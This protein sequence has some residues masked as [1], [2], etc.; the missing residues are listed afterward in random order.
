QLPP[1]PLRQNGVYLITGGMGGLGLIFAEYLAKNLQS[2]LVL[3]SR[4]APK[5]RQEEKLRQLKSYGAEVLSLQADVSK[6]EDVQMAVRE[7]KARFSAIH[8]VIHAAGVNRDAFILKKTKEEME[9][10]LGPKV[11][12]TINLDLATSEEN[13]D[14][15]VL[16]S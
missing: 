16:F 13:L 2:K 9:A 5:A 1:L 10:V 7:A 8:G 14:W 6:L 12:G 11:Y 3:V 4:S 15:L